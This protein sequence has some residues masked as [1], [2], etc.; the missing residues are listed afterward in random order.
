MTLALH[1]QP[2]GSLR[3]NALTA[4]DVIAMATATYA[5]T[6]ALYFNTPIATSFAGASVPFAFLLSTVA[7]LIVA[8]CMAQ[9][10]KHQASAGGYYSWIRSA[11]GQRSGFIVGWLVLAGS[12]LVVPGVYAG[13][14]DYVSTILARYGVKLNWIIIALVL[15]VL[16][17]AFNIVGVRTS[18]RTGLVILVVELLIVTALCVVVVAKGGAAGNTVAPFKPPSGFGSLGGAMVFGVLSF[19][20]FEAVATT[21]EEA[22]KARRHIPL[23]LFLAV[24]IG[25]VFL[26]FGSYAAVI[27]FGTN[28]V[29]DLAAN[30]AP[31]DTLAERFANPEFRL[32]I[33]IAGVTSFTASL[34]LTTL[35]VSRIYFAM[36][37]DKLL[38]AALGRVSA[39]HKTP[40]VAVVAETALALVLFVIL[41]EWVGPENTYAYLG[42]VL[43]F[44]MV[45]VYVLIFV[46]TFVVFRTSLRRLFNPF[47]HV[48]LPLI[49][50]AV[51]V[52]PLWSLSPLGGPQSPPYDY[53]PL[54]VLI[55]LVVGIALTFVLRHRFARAEAVIGRAAFEEAREPEA[56]PTAR[57]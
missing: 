33:D 10:A 17:T 42:T 21:G 35:A 52:Y 40:V 51:M 9:L 8:A 11:L 45:P 41:G 27:G 20:G 36:A 16:V 46:S 6:A 30:A 1:S 57:T 18:V 12:F 25:G 53:L 39:R 38:P 26:T 32:A 50:I 13:E 24:I 48:V 44:S 3:R 15:L 37:R 54:V 55:Y 29:S 31:F 14:S 22:T 2:D 23:A 56:Q 28:H 5:P 43:T 49:G 4:T 34:L 7:M 47:L 19:V